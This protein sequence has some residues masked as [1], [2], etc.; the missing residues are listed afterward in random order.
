MHQYIMIT[1]YISLSPHDLIYL[2]LITNVL[3]LNTTECNMKQFGNVL[4]VVRVVK[5]SQRLLVK[6]AKT[7]L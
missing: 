4:Q 7:R 1:S 2:H 6:K 3:F 5:T